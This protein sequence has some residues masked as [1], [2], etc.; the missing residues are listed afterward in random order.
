M[1]KRHVMVDLETLGT[2]NRAA[3]IQIGA[4]IFDPDKFGVGS[5]TIPTTTI[6]SSVQYNVTAQSSILLGDGVVD[7]S[8]IDWWRG[9]DEEARLK[10]FA[11]EEPAIS[12]VEALSSLK[13]F[14]GECCPSGVDGYWSH[15][16]NFDIEILNGYYS[17]MAGI[18]FCPF[19]LIRDTRTLFDV[20]KSAGWVRG[21]RD[22]SLVAH[23]AVDDAIGQALDTCDALYHLGAIGH[24]T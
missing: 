4:C 6:V 5:K 1:S 19:R 9:Q 21:D 10:V 15:G 22:P 13:S 12:I 14:I 24:R 17:R 2:S 8:T 3:I 23:V 16:S 18:E 20:A 7:Q 11:S